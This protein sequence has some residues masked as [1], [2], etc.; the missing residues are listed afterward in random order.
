MLAF[1]EKIIHITNLFTYSLKD[2]SKIINSF[3][4]EKIYT[5]A[6][7]LKSAI[8]NFGSD[9]LLNIAVSKC[10]K[11]EIINKFNLRY[12]KKISSGEDLCFN[13]EYLKHINNIGFSDDI[14]YCYVRRDVE[15]GV[16]SYKSNIIHM[17]ETCLN[18]VKDL[19]KYYNL[20]DEKSLILLGNFY[21]DYISNGIYNLYRKNCKLSVKEKRNVIKKLYSLDEKKLNS[22]ND[23]KDIL[24]KISTYLIKLDNAHI[25]NALYFILFFIRNNFSSCYYWIRNKWIHKGKR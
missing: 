11:R 17:T 1:I 18:A 19:Y 2:N 7:D 13:S 14:S 25:S 12:N 4:E 9:G 3:K 16:N 23:R 22:F 5:G 10:F 15:S 8:K 24:S 21:I 20:D 6:D